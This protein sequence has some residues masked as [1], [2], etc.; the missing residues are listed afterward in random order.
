LKNKPPALSCAII[1]CRSADEP[2]SHLFEQ[3]WAFFPST[4]RVRTQ[5]QPVAGA[6]MVV[7]E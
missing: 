3:A 1:G 7:N 2:L 6:A 5:V 4:R